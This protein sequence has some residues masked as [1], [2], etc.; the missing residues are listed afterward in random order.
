MG[1]TQLDL[2]G[3]DRVMWSNDYCHD[4]GTFLESQRTIERLF[5]GIGEATQRKLMWENAAQLYGR[6]CDRILKDR[7]HIAAD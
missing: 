3:P 5:A 2:V 4:E 1:M 7:T 6:D